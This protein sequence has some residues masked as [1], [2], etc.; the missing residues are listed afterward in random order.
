MREFDAIRAR[1]AAIGA[2]HLQCI[3][4]GSYPG[5]YSL[6]E[7]GEDW[8]NEAWADPDGYFSDPALPTFLAA[9]PADIDTLLARIAALERVL[10]D[11]GSVL[12]RAQDAC[13]RTEQPAR[14]Q[15]CYIARQQIAALFPPPD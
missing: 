8:N 15:D 9:A 6:V 5:A 3:E 4:S 2:I 10:V 12:Q 1:R 13:D 11:V 14:A 7:R